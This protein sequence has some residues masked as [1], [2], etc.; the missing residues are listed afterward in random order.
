M[1]CSNLL[2]PGEEEFGLCDECYDILEGN[3]Y[4]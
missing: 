1:R 3:P 2:L 4:N